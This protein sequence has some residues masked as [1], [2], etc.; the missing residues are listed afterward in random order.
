MP[1]QYR[2]IA[3]FTAFTLAV[4]GSILQVNQPV[5]AKPDGSDVV[6]NEFYGRGGS[7]NQPY[8]KKFVELYNPAKNEIDLTGMSLAY[9]SATN[10]GTPTAGCQLTGK[11]QPSGYYLIELPGNGEVGESLAG[12]DQQC[13]LTPSGT[14]GALTLLRGADQVDLVGYGTA[15]RNEG[16]AAK[17]DGGNSDP[18]SIQRKQAVDTDNNAADFEFTA[19]PSPQGSGTNGQQNP[20][21]PNAE[22]P[23]PQPADTVIAIA[24]IQGTGQ[25]TPL[26]SKVVTTLGVVTA[27]Y[28]TGGFNGF[29]MQTPG[30][31]GII[32]AAS[33]GIFVYT[34]SA[35][36]VEVGKCYRV[37]G[38]AGEHNGLTQLS[39]PTA[40]VNE[41]TGCEAAKAV[42]LTT[43]P[44]DAEKERLEGMLVLP[45]GAYTITNNYQ[46][47]QYGQLGLAIGDKP[48]YVATEKVLPGEQ[49]E[50]YEAE[51]LKKYIT[52][53]DGSSWDYMKNKTAQDSRLPYLSQDTPMRTG[54]Q[55]SFD[56]P[57]ILDFRFQWNF[58]PTGH[59]VGHDSEN[60][61]IKSE[62]DRPATAPRVGGDIQIASF[63]VL[64]YFTD[65]GKDEAGCK[66]YDDREGNPVGSN[67][68]T[69]RG[70]YSEKAFENQQ[71]KIVSAING[72]DA[73]IVALMEMETSS[74]FG[75][76]R[77]YSLSKLVEALN[78]GIANKAD[79]WDYVRSP[80]VVPD[81][82]D[83]IRL[84]YI[85]KPSAVSPKDA[86]QILIDTAFANARQPLAQ[87]WTTVKNDKVEFVTIANHFK[88]K[89]SG[90]DDGTGQGKSNPSR[91]AQAQALTKWVDQ[92]AKDDPVFLMGDFNAYSKE[93]PVRII[94]AAGFTE[95]EGKFAPEAS[96]Y[97][98]GGRLGSLDHNFANAKGLAM[99]SGAGVWDINGDESIAMQYSRRNYNV[100]DFHQDGP[101]ASSDHDPAIFGLNIPAPS[102]VPTPSPTPSA[103][104]KP[105]A[106]VTA[107]A[108][109]TVTQTVTGPTTTVTARGPVTTTTVTGPTATVTISAPAAT[110][111]VTATQNV[112]G[113][114]STVTTTQ[115]VPGPTV[116]ET[117]QIAGPT[118]TV[119]A[120]RN[121]P[122]PTVT[123]TRN[124]P[125]PT[126]TVTSGT[127]STPQVIG[128]IA[129]AWAQ[130]GGA[131]GYFG[132]PTSGEIA[133]GGH[134]VVQHFE[135]G[136][137]YWAPGAGAWFVHDGNRIEW[138]RLG[139]INGFL[140]APTGNE[141]SLGGNVVVQTFQGGRIYWS[142]QFG[143]R[144]VHG[145]ILAK[146]LAG[147]GH[148]V[149]GVPTTG[150]YPFVGG[151]RQDFVGSV[152]TWP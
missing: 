152:I 41:T 7:A 50:A 60:I 93:D 13:G 21:A 9:Q 22:P 34:G 10:N 66:S 69:V 141:V 72:L 14:K 51:N 87:R 40:I 5:Q 114:T 49:A 71:A 119:T 139:G 116:T 43:L 53:D 81:S 108:T 107:T 151:V 54:S 31:G 134:R 20:P 118:A 132:K 96:T 70:A 30:S 105:T 110:T 32:P 109:A 79:Q 113:P 2:R 61:P 24:D 85:Y 148:E 100:V 91:K 135:H 92:I 80:L 144:A 82:E 95:L 102:V 122:G 111:T 35:P 145:G 126:V 48:L 67:Y 131:D 56:K 65:L 124:V 117:K 98:F 104:V 150:E 75:H 140:G 136:D 37:T 90:D 4:G 94:E 25:E 29:Y 147:G 59:V 42:E 74:R 101:F 123:V 78:A 58:Q 36:S 27:S 26:K 84:A 137:A 55:V 121:V 57:V 106:T 115:N 15:V 52:L 45:K 6:I 8:N 133:L 103:T 120:T 127:P 77:D 39:K 146:F 76:S 97:Q 83:V 149:L 18:G 62:N 17:Y 64:N 47:N 88:S 11:I 23:A 99:V 63:N 89:G 46:L 138:E 142:P 112:P 16:A 86:S 44:S 68:C 1:Q 28:P 143:A 129:F 12:V 3:A 38:T 33:Q 73:E 128:A 130:A 19:T 125:G